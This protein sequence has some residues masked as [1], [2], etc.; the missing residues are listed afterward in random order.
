VLKADP[1]SQR[2]RPDGAREEIDNRAVCVR[3]PA[4]IRFGLMGSRSLAG[5]LA[6]GTFTKAPYGAGAGTI[7]GKGAL[8]REVAPDGALAW[9]ARGRLSPRALL[10]LLSINR[11]NFSAIVRSKACAKNPWRA[12]KMNAN[13]NTPLTSGTSAAS[14]EP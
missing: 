10:A 7:T 6:E 9:E 14:F 5:L 12:T 1:A 3:I 11:C 4:E 2:N 13:N 8:D